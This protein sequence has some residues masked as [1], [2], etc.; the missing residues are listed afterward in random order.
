MPLRTRPRT[1]DKQQD[2]ETQIG[3][4]M[5]GLAGE[6]ASYVLAGGVMGWL[7]DMWLGTEWWLVV[8]FVTGIVTGLSVLLRGALKMN[9]ILDRDHHARAATRNPEADDEGQ[10][11]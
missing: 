11:P 10:H 6:T 9:R 7:L 8:G 2:R 4:R 3:W 5:A 1:R